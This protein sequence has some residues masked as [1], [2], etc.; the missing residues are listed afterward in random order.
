M[1]SMGYT[2][3]YQSCPR[4]DFSNIVGIVLLL[5]VLA[6]VEVVVE[7]VVIEVIVVH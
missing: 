1:N 7:A 4:V 5:F 3:G 2:V 6:L